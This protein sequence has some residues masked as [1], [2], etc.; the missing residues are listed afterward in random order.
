MY[1][2]IYS[3]KNQPNNKIKVLNYYFCIKNF[4]I[5]YDYN[6]NLLFITEWNLKGLIIPPL[7]LENLNIA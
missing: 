5:F 4:N 6:D 2:K 1:H 7:F 3:F